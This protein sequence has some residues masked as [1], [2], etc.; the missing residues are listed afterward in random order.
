MADLKHQIDIEASPEQVYAALATSEGLASW[1]TADARAEQRIGG[2]AEFGFNKRA[3]VYRMT[4]GKLD[5]GK[6]VVWGCQGDNP[7]WAGTKLSWT[8]TPQRA[9]CVLRFTHGGWKSASDFFAMC[10]STW[11]ELMYRLKGYLEGRAPGPRWTE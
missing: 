4:I 10:N 6:E 11:G 1:W 9:G 3:A 2:K 8:I 5:P 7:E